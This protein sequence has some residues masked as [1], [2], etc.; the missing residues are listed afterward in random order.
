[1][2]KNREPARAIFEG[3]RRRFGRHDPKNDL[4]VAIVRGISNTKPLDYAVIIG[5]NLE[6]VP[7]TTSDLLRFVSRFH[8]MEPV[9]HQ[10]LETFLGAFRRQRR[11]FLV[12]VHLPAHESQPQ[13]M[14]DLGLG[15]YDLVV[16]EAWEIGEND[17]DGAV[18]D[19]D[20]PP[21]IPLDQP[22]APALK[23]LTKLKALRQRRG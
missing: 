16:R 20:D 19:L 11:Y 18:L 8:R 14:L 5:Q 6:N 4:R 17:P 21:I 10:H 9:N 12:P 13:P 1:M 22:N 2:Y 15:K 23:A 3:L 7:T